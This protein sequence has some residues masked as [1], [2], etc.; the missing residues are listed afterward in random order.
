[1]SATST[2]AAAAAATVAASARPN[3][4]TALIQRQLELLRQT[5]LNFVQNL[6]TEQHDGTN[7]VTGI[8]TGPENSPYA[9]NQFDF[10]LRFPLEY[11]F[12][13]PAVH[14]ITPI[15]HPNIS[16]KDGFA[17]DDVL[18]GTWT[19]KMNLID[20]LNGTHSL[21]ANPNY[22]KPVDSIPSPDSNNQK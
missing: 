5:P 21:L 18:I 8:M 22:D 3:K 17:C 20:V 13:P 9:G 12:K 2:V 10:I 7:E 19:T 6:N 14:F 15:N 16:S 1:M 4:Q 11:P